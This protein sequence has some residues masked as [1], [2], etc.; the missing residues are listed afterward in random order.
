MQDMAAVLYY[1]EML[2]KQEKE[3]RRKAEQ[4]AERQKLRAFILDMRK[5][6]GKESVSNFSVVAKPV[7]EWKKEVNDLIKHFQNKD[8]Y[9]GYWEADSFIA[10]LLD[11]FGNLYALLSICEDK[12]AIDASMWLY[13]RIHYIGVDDSSTGCTGY[14]ED[15]MLEF[16]TEVAEYS[17]RNK[18]H[19]K[20]ALTD[21]EHHYIARDEMLDKLNKV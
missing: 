7:S 3:R 16:W 4:K 18:K 2:E 21:Y 11:F 19:L 5:Q 1:V 15:E 8:G 14:F 13:K 20:T 12:K 6:F 9:I 10:N 17:E